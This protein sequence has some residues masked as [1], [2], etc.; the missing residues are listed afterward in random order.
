MR[1]GSFVKKPTTGWLHDDA[2]LTPPGDG[3]YYPVTVR[4]A[5]ARAARALLTA[6]GAV[7]GEYSDRK[8]DADDEL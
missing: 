4:G 3:V 5:R 8:V 2:A 1:S 7:C 6:T